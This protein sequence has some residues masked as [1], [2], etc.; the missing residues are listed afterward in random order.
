MCVL[1]VVFVYFN[2]EHLLSNLLALAPPQII[3]RKRP[4][5]LRCTFQP[6]LP[7]WSKERQL[8]PSSAQDT[9]VTLDPEAESGSEDI[10]GGLIDTSSLRAGRGGVD[11]SQGKAFW[12]GGAPSLGAVA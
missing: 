5:M 9:G 10:G 3:S 4:V 8:F 7:G 11:R 12:A 2:S 6:L 1:E